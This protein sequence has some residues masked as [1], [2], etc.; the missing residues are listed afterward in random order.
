[1][2]SQP[3]NPEF[4]YNPENS[5]MHPMCMPHYRAAMLFSINFTGFQYRKVKPFQNRRPANSVNPDEMA[6]LISS[7][8]TLFAYSIFFFLHLNFCRV[9]FQDLSYTPFQHNRLFYNLKWKSLHQ[10]L[11]GE[12]FKSVNRNFLESIL[13][14]FP[15]C[16]FVHHLH[17]RVIEWLPP[18][19]CFIKASVFNNLNRQN[20]V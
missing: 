15:C 8:S 2:E 17:E 20:Y 19:S 11:R 12:R 6:H 7:G 16:I 9:F 5:P 4:R 13:N 14:F 1:M 3:Q 18:L 10:N